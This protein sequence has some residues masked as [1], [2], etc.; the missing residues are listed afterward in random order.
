MAIADHLVDH[1]IVHES[2]GVIV[3]PE[4]IELRIGGFQT[5]RLADEELQEVETGPIAAER[6]LEHDQ[7]GPFHVEI[8]EGL[9]PLDGHPADR[10]G[11][12]R[13]RRFQSQHSDHFTISLRYL[14][15]LI[16]KLYRLNP[17]KKN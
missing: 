14:K 11:Q 12:V 7:S 9:Q 8:Q 15:M 10:L 13:F 4:M 16:T 5:L 6:L 2:E 17:K 1:I 3:E